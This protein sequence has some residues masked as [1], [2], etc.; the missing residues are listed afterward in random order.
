[1]SVDEETARTLNQIAAILKV[2]HQDAIDEFGAE[3][4]KDD[5]RQSS[6]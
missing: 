5:T 2:A 4:L 6:P 3:I 1:M